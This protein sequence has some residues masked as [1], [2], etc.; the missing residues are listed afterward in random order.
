MVQMIS[1]SLTHHLYQNHQ[2][3]TFRFRWPEDVRNEV[4]EQHE[5]HKS[6]KTVHLHEAV[7]KRDVLLAFCKK[8]VRTIRSGD[9]RE[10]EKLRE[11]L[12]SQELFSKD[13]I[14]ITPDKN[15]EY[16]FTKLQ[17]KKKVT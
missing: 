2:T 7:N 17:Q 16:F 13:D 5:L 12:R 1:K 6:L 9:R 11:K 3:W 14:L 15:Q 4:G 8:L 10:F